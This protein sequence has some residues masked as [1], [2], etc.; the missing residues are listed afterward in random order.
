VTIG[1]SAGDGIQLDWLI[2]VSSEHR[3][4]LKYTAAFCTAGLVTSVIGAFMSRTSYTRCAVSRGTPT[5]ILEDILVLLVSSQ[6]TGI[7]LEF[8]FYFL[9]FYVKNYK[10]SP[11]PVEKKQREQEFQKSC[12]LYVSNRVFIKVNDDDNVY[13]ND[14]IDDNIYQFINRRMIPRR[15]NWCYRFM[16][17]NQREVAQANMLQLSILVHAQFLW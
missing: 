17:L 5:M 12:S 6:W 11:V 7:L 15:I 4:S 3:Y 9:Y 8:L 13:N 10:G 1:V 2:R 16:A 14:E